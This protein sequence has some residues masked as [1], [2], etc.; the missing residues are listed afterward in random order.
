MIIDI[1]YSNSN[2]QNNFLKDINSSFNIYV[3]VNRLIIKDIL[4]N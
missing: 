3:Y 1:Y 4:C 2:N